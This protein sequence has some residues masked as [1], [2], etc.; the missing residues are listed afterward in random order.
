MTT[1][2][3]LHCLLEIA[4]N[5]A[6]D[7]ESP[8]TVQVCPGFVLR[9]DPKILLLFSPKVISPFITAAFLPPVCCLDCL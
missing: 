6:L 5:Q 1:G 8:T 3:D 7:F 9:P 2:T 4:W